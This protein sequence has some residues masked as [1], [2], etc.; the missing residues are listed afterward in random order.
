MNSLRNLHRKAYTIVTGDAAASSGL[1]TM[2]A[3]RW[4]D[5]TVLLRSAGLAKPEIAYTRACTPSIVD[6]VRVLP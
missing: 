6:Q 3:Q 1:P 4:R 5:T 2:T